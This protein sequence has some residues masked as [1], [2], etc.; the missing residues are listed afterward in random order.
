MKFDRANIENRFSSIMTTV[1]SICLTY[2]KKIDTTLATIFFITYAYLTCKKKIAIN[3]AYLTCKS[4]DPHKTLIRIS[5]F[6]DIQF[7]LLSRQSTPRDKF[8]KLTVF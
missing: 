8:Y 7:T 4:V 1:Y 6:L 5:Y 2:K 3:N